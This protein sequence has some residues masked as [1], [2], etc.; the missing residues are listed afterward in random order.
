MNR[1]Q[2]VGIDTKNK[3][4]NVNTAERLLG[5]T[6]IP[7]NIM[8]VH[9]FCKLEVRHRIKSRQELIS[10]ILEISFHFPSCVRSIRRSYLLLEFTAKLFIVALRRAV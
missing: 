2:H 4:W 8:G 10:L 5:S 1:I 6:A 7:S 9:L 3:R